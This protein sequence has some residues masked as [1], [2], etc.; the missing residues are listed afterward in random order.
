MSLTENTVSRGLPLASIL[1]LH[2]ECQARSGDLLSTVSSGRE[3][4]R[5][6]VGLGHE[7]P[8]D[9]TN[10]RG[11]GELRRSRGQTGSGHRL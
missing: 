3:I 7:T 11:Q 1:L 8:N 4:P 9:Q 2:G 6:V 5:T 10:H